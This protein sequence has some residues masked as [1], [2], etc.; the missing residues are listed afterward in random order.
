MPILG[1]EAGTAFASLY[2]V[3][4]LIFA[5]PLLEEIDPSRRDHIVPF[6]TAQREAEKE[7]L[8]LSEGKH[9]AHHLIWHLWASKNCMCWNVDRLHPYPNKNSSCKFEVFQMGFVAVSNRYQKLRSF[10]DFRGRFC[11]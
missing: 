9:Q 11:A 2:G 3:I 7:I 10:D 4:S 6:L 5:D 8:H 1:L